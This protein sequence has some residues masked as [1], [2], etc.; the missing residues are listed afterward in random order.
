MNK[1]GTMRPQNAT[2]DAGYNPMHPL[3]TMQM[4]GM[5]KVAE[6]TGRS[7]RLVR[8]ASG[9]GVKLES[10]RRPNQARLDDLRAFMDDQKVCERRCWMPTL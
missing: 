1:S 6:I 9:E 5:D 3:H 8:S 7:K 4:C 2:S 10:R